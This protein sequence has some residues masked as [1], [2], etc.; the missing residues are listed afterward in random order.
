[1]KG[2]LCQLIPFSGEYLGRVA[3]WLSTT[4]CEALLR[5]TSSRLTRESQYA[6]LEDQAE[7]IAR[8]AALVADS[9]G[10]VVG[11]VHYWRL[12][13]GV[14]EVGGATGDPR[15]WGT[16]IG[17]EAAALL[18]DYLFEVL[19]C[20]RVEFTSGI[21]NEATIKLGLSDSMPFEAVCRDYFAAPGGAIP[22]VKSS[23]LREEYNQ[24]YE[25]YVPRVGRR[26][27][28]ARLARRTEALAR[29]I[30]VQRI[31]DRL[32]GEQW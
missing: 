18:V 30:D 1:M 27:D 8:R 23:L 7:G 32:S 14:Y 25:H 15:L 11:L 17:V 19:N 21:H 26:L 13:E 29:R 6:G 2:L 12:G 31:T 28:A 16:G 3:K 4:E 24:P 5:G 10:E 20:R 22:A 9:R